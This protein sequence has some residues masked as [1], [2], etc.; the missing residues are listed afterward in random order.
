M[1]SRQA[2]ILV[3]VYNRPEHLRRCVESL[4]A[5]AESRQ[6]D[7]CV[8]SD[9]PGRSADEAAVAEARK[10]IR[11]IGGFRS[12]TAIER[13]KNLGS[14][15]SITA[16]ISAVLPEHG[17]LIFLEDDNIVSPR[18]LEFMNRGLAFYEDDESV[19]SVSGYGYPVSMPRAYPFDVYKYRGFC[20]WGAGLWLN[21]WRAVD[22][23][24]PGFEALRANRAKRRE[25]DLAG[26]HVYPQLAR[27]IRAGVKT[28]DSIIVYHLV[29]KRLYSIFP[30]V[31]RVRNTGTD[32]S[33]E[34]CGA[35]GVYS[36]QELD[37]GREY[38]FSP[39]L[40]EDE[41]INRILRRYFS[42]PAR[43]KLAA[44]VAPLIPPRPKRW[45]KRLMAMRNRR[46]L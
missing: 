20:A 2:P 27:D 12:V 35:D 8:V 14:F 38:S 5:N 41:D 26:E 23:D 24:C 30:V 28:A 9:A 21:R 7:L 32:G 46:R 29:T 11:E 36:D 25:L 22:W 13:P 45:I 6:A 44:R 16:A 31:S 4:C 40:A 18:F 15:G 19:F 3:S 39:W 10:F 43:R 34:H 17:R 33:G 37:A 1:N 42:I